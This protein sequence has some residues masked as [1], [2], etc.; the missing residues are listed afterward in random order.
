MESVMYTIDNPGDPGN[1]I[2]MAFPRR[3]VSIS[4][5]SITLSVSA[6]ISATFYDANNKRLDKTYLELSGA[7]YSSWVNDEWLVNHV[8]TNLGV[9]ILE[10]DY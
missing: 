6:T 7:E 1:L 8:L 5:V 3:Y 10:S 4:V 9:T 2:G